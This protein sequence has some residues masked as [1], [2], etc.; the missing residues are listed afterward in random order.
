MRKSY[1]SGTLQKSGQVD[2]RAGR[3]GRANKDPPFWDSK[4]VI[5]FL[6]GKHNYER[7]LKHFWDI[8]F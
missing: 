1:S 5:F 8:H 2:R 7:F 4:D 6:F 3:V